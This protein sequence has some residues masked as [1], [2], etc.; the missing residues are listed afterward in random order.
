MSDVVLT[1]DQNDPT[2]FDAMLR[3]I[4]KSPSIACIRELIRNAIDSHLDANQ[5]KKVDIQF[6]DKFFYLRDYGTGITPKQLEN[7]LSVV[8]RS[9]KRNTDSKA[10]GGY[11]LGSKTVFGVL[12]E[13]IRA[14]RDQSE[15][16]MTSITGGVKRVYQLLVDDGK[17]KYRLLIEVDTDEPTG[18]SY[19]IEMNDSMKRMDTETFLT[20]FS[21]I[22]ENLN[23]IGGLDF[24]DYIENVKIGNYVVSLIKRPVD[25]TEMPFYVSVVTTNKGFRLETSWSDSTYKIMFKDMIYPMPNTFKH[26]INEED[27]LEYTERKLKDEKEFIHS[28]DDFI[29]TLDIGHESYGMEPTKPRDSLI[30]ESMTDIQTRNFNK[31]IK[32]SNVIET[33][34]GYVLSAVYSTLRR[35]NAYLNGNSIHSNA[36]IDEGFYGKVTKLENITTLVSHYIL[37][38]EFLSNIK[39]RKVR[40]LAYREFDVCGMEEYF[41][42]EFIRMLFS[43]DEIFG[44][45]IVLDGSQMVEAIKSEFLTVYEKIFEKL[46]ITSDITDVRSQNSYMQPNYR[47][48]VFEDRS[49][50][51]LKTAIDNIVDGTVHFATVAKLEDGKIMYQNE[52]KYS[53]NSTTNV[54]IWYKDRKSDTRKIEKWLLDNPNETLLIVERYPY[55]DING[56]DNSRMVDRNDILSR[57]YKRS[58]M[59]MVLLDYH[60]E[61]PIEMLSDVLP[62]IKVKKQPKKKRDKNEL[63]VNDLTVTARSVEAYNPLTCKYNSNPTYQD[64]VDIVNG[65][66]KV[67]VFKY[68]E[69]SITKNY[70]GNS[71]TVIYDYSTTGKFSIRVKNNN[72]VGHYTNY[73]VNPNRNIGVIYLCGR[74]S[75]A[76]SEFLNSNPK[77]DDGN[78]YLNL[79]INEFESNGFKEIFDYNI[80]CMYTLKYTANDIGYNHLLKYCSSE[81]QTKRDSSGSSS[82]MYVYGSI[83]NKTYH[84]VSEHLIKR[85]I[86]DNGD[87]YDM[88]YN[89]GNIML[90]EC[91]PTE[92]SNYVK[93][94]NSRKDEFKQLIDRYT[95]YE[96][97]IVNSI[98]QLVFQAL[99]DNRDCHTEIT[100]ME[101]IYKI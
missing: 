6:T 62:T 58:L 21:P 80:G 46:D 32:D 56:K 85:H 39:E 59:K 5:D 83:A 68:N 61:H 29:I 4:Y 22:I 42:S 30:T 70:Y 81:L 96:F 72:S 94:L 12:Y 9:G 71:F 16:F 47:D 92:I 74:E 41:D 48:I 49:T 14:G 101:K 57:T 67:I 78:Q 77:V 8:M 34:K 76:I 28:C 44:A 17:P 86:I 98:I 66:D 91:T 2:F 100:E 1:M 75:N 84:T 50:Y 43:R 3:S 7:L 88:D 79:L 64:I 65:N 25:V 13:D 31:F 36:L 87:Y 27:L 24:N 51:T 73:N 90:F 63:K 15:V 38:N 45:Y 35:F 53:F 40:N 60:K 82:H 99:S 23:F 26:L 55:H 97:M 20:I 19:H 11:G 18:L 37:S 10:T 93:E 89:H 54:T 52:T 69:S 33:H 95:K